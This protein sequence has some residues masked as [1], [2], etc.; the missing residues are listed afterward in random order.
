MRCRVRVIFGV[1]QG[2]HVA[3]FPQKG[4]AAVKIL[5]LHL[6]CLVLICHSWQLVSAWLWQMDSLLCKEN[7]IQKIHQTIHI[8]QSFQSLISH[9]HGWK[10]ESAFVSCV[11]SLTLEKEPLRSHWLKKPA[12]RKQTQK[13]PWRSSETETKN[14]HTIF[15]K[16]IN[17]PA[18]HHNSH[19]KPTPFLQLR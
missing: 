5:L 2:S 19:H 12:V 16:Y 4:M 8:N 9:Q 10:S 6:R 1:S 18:T 17:Y 15:N 11:R 13:D 14:D 3:W 7:M